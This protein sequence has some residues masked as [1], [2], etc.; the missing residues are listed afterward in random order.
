MLNARINYVFYLNTFFILSIFINK[1]SLLLVAALLVSF[2]FR[3][4]PKANYINIFFPLILYLCLHF[5]IN[6]NYVVFA[7]K[8][9]FFLSSCVF[10]FTAP[11]FLS[12][13]SCSRRSVE[14]AVFL[15]VFYVLSL[16]TF[17]GIFGVSGISRLALIELVQTQGG[18][19]LNRIASMLCLALVILTFYQISIYKLLVFLIFYLPFAVLLT[20]RLMILVFL[21]CVIIYSLRGSRWS[22][23][24]FSVFSSVFGSYLFWFRYDIVQTFGWRLAALFD[25]R[26]G[27]FSGTIERLDCISS[28]RDIVLGNAFCLKFADPLTAFDNQLF[29]IFVAGGL[30]GLIVLAIAFSLMLIVLVKHGSKANTILFCLV[31]ILL[32]FYDEG[33]GKPE[34]L[35]ILFL[36]SLCIGSVREGK[37]K[38][39]FV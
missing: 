22:I 26:D 35:S 9:L 39:K 4:H 18:I 27:R 25:G 28:V 13:T 32:M 37:T 14:L 2:Q 16:L 1:L 19:Y 20:S 31:S 23:L 6:A 5:Y 3:R 7:S 38:L 11:A 34:Y 24:I 33:F 29:F 30:I 12:L 36:Y 10:I 8:D 15:Y 17:S 21:L